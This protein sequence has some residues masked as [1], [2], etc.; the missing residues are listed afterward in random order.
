MKMREYVT[1]WEFLI[2]KEADMV[3]IQD[4]NMKEINIYLS[5]YSLQFVMSSNNT[6]LFMIH[7]NQIQTQWRHC[8]ETVA[9]P[10]KISR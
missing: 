5:L 10:E 8:Q 4:L 1:L 7:L 9:P 3:E 2:L 6:H